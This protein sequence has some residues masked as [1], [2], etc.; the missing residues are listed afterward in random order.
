M[1]TRSLPLQRI[2][3]EIGKR[4]CRISSTL[5]KSSG[6]VLENNIL[7][8]PFHIIDIRILEQKEGNN[9]LVSILPVSVAHQDVP[10]TAVYVGPQNADVAHFYDLA[11]FKIETPTFPRCLLFC[12]RRKICN[13]AKKFILEATLFPTMFLTFHKGRVSS[14]YEKGSLSLFTIDATTVPGNSGGAVFVMRDNQ[15]ALAGISFEQVGCG[16]CFRRVQDQLRPLLEQATLQ[17]GTVRLNVLLSEVVDTVFNNLS[18]G[19]GNVL[20][21]RHIFDDLMKQQLH[22]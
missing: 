9:S 19:I 3:A 21:A 7:V 20:H 16:S 11:F 10:Y 18:T 5:G 2:Y 12:I 17:L 8:V 6:F 15:I 1:I 14:S 13:L 4:V 22:P